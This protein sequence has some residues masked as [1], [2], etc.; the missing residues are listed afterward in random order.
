MKLKDLSDLSS[1]EFS[2]L[3]FFTVVI[4]KCQW[5]VYTHTSIYSNLI[6]F[7]D[8]KYISHSIDPLSKLQCKRLVTTWV[9]LHTQTRL[10]CLNI[11]VLNTRVC[12]IDIWY[13]PLTSVHYNL[14]HGL[15]TLTESFSPLSLNYTTPLVKVWI[16]SDSTSHTIPFCHTHQ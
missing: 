11:Q 8:S 13:T 7:N 5:L 12:F 2:Y 10:H 3:F 1:D 9:S 4:N 14:E 6:L 15:A 16:R